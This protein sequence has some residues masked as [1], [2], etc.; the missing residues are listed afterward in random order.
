MSTA[1]IDTPIC[2]ECRKPTTWEGNVWRPFSSERC[3]QLD[4]GAW[5]GEQYRVAGPSLT[6]NASESSSDE[7]N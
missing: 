4:L 1:K 2:P 6:V 5:S 3:Q 7:R